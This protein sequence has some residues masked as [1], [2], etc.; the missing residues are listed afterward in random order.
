[1][2]GRL[3]KGKRYIVLSSCDY[4]ESERTINVDACGVLEDTPRVRRDLITGSAQNDRL[5]GPELP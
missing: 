2:P 4:Q 3:I 1:M 5:R